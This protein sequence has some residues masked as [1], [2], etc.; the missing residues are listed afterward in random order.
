MTDCR[1]Q[2]A[3]HDRTNPQN[4]IMKKTTHLLMA[5]GCLTALAGITTIPAMAKDGQTE[6]SSKKPAVVSSIH[7]AGEV[8]D[9]DLPGLAKISF[10][11]ALKAAE[12]AVK[13][14]V[15]QGELEAEDGSLMY[16]FEIVG[17][18][19]TVNQVEIDP[20]NGKVLSAGVD[21]SDD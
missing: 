17:P 5:L 15:I 14:N 11:D 19:K 4:Q 18:D 6:D 3:Y 1:T 9:A 8:D 7:V 21:K 10:D 2:S 20:G 13:G 12:K 16:S